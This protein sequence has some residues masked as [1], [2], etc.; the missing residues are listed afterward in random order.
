MTVQIHPTALVDPTAELAS[1]VEVG[2]YA[3]VGPNTWIGSGTQI[4]NHAVIHGNTTLG[5][6]CRV[7]VGA[8]IGGLPQHREI[9][10]PE[11]ARVEIGDRVVI[12]EYATIHRANGDGQ[13]TRIGEDCLLMAYSHV[14]HDCVLG[15][16]VLL[17]NL[18][19]L[20]GY[21]TVEEAAFL[22][23]RV[24]VHQFVRIGRL[25]MIGASSTVLQDVL[26]FAM[27]VGTPA[28]ICGVNTVGLRRH[29][30]SDEDRG[31]IHRAYGFFLSSNLTRPQ[32]MAALAEEQKQAPILSELATFL[33][34]TQRGV[35]FRKARR[36]VPRG[37]PDRG[38]SPLKGEGSYRFIARLQPP[39]S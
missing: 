10:S 31:A 19:Q 9:V 6:Q 20:A 29:G 17:A 25:A 24:V 1:G 7:G 35:R 5:A 4:D 3:F 36:R 26:P 32:A 2:P 33:E 37:Q 21:V 34:E 15:P 23:G 8:V 14:A 28:E 27:V 38:V 16:R 11:T 18:V 39:L 22:G 13:V 30:V 12:R